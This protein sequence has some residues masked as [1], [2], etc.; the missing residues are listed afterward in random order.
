MIHVIM[1][2]A[3]GTILGVNIIGAKKDDKQT[4]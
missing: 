4:E 3:V 2:A 1:G